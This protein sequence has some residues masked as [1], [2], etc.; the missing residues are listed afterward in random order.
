MGAFAHPEGPLDEA[1]VL[2]AARGETRG[3]TPEDEPHRLFTKILA[4]LSPAPKA[5]S[6][7]GRRGL[8]T[9]VFRLLTQVSG[10]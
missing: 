2:L 1:D 9:Q 7:S 3:E 6:A 4:T 5:T 10:C 8:L